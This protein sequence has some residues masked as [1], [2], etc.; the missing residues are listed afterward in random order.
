MKLLNC[1]L[2]VESVNGKD[3]ND[4]MIDYI[5]EMDCVRFEYF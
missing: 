5:N 4:S 3:F 2:I 1:Y